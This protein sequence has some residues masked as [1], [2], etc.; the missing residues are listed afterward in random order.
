MYLALVL[1]YDCSMAKRKNPAAV[2]LGRRGAKARLKS[3]TSEQRSAQA[4]LAVQARWSK[5]NGKP[6]EATWYGL[7][8]LPV[9]APH[10][11]A[12]FGKMVDE[13]N[14]APQVLFWSQERS[15]VVKRSQE[16]D[17]DDRYTVIIE[18]G[19]NPKAFAIRRTFGPDAE[20]LKRML[21]AGGQ[22]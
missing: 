20:A 13:A 15:E 4:R 7:L 14:A 8:L 19:W 21:Q 6:Q 9:R 11:A 12:D 22:W 5:I 3:L 1:K 18:Q 17:L 2:A 16:P 10:S